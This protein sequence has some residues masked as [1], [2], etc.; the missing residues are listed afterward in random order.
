M[1]GIFFIIEPVNKVFTI[2]HLQ[3]SRPFWK[4][5]VEYGDKGSTSSQ[6]EVFYKLTPLLILSVISTK[7]LKN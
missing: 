2:G 6:A 1:E 4:N 7:P 3:N 5:K